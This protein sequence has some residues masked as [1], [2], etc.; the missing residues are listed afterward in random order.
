M[1][2][3]IWIHRELVRRASTRHLLQTCDRV[4]ASLNRLSS[5][6][7]ATS[8]NTMRKISSG[9]LLIGQCCVLTRIVSLWRITDRIEEY[10]WAGGHPLPWI[11]RIEIVYLAVTCFVLLVWYDITSVDL[12]QSERESPLWA[13]S[14][15]ARSIFKTVYKASKLTSKGVWRIKRWVEQTRLSEKSPSL[16]WRAEHLTAFLWEN[17]VKISVIQPRQSLC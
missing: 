13:G 7:W 2:I 4:V 5:S 16:A 6:I 9:H 1:D 17:F 12:S 11:C 15:M 8:S 14:R 10:S 3:S